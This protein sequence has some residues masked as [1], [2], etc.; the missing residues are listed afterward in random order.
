MVLFSCCF[1]CRG[2]YDGKLYEKCPWWKLCA[3]ISIYLFFINYFFS[4]RCFFGYTCRGAFVE[5]LLVRLGRGGVKKW[6]KKPQFSKFDPHS[7]PFKYPR[8]KQLK[9]PSNTNY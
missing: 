1:L 6:P 8:K 2:F 9:A 5:C 3:L 7:G 4:V